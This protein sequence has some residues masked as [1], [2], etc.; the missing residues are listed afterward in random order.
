ME[1]NFIVKENENL[2]FKI[3][4]IEEKNKFLEI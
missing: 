4:E 3:K 2:I 1:K